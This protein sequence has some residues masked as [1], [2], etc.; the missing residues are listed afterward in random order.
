MTLLFMIVYKLLTEKFVVETA[1]IY[2]Y[3]GKAIWMK[4]PEGYPEFLD[5][6][7]GIVINPNLYCVKVLKAIYGLR[8][9]AWPWWKRFKASMAKLSYYSRLADPCLFARNVMSTRK[10]S[11]VIICV[12]DGGIFRSQK[13]IDDIITGLSKDFDMKPLGKMKDL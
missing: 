9:A 6:V 11:I 1:F 3:L 2:S 7:H 5:E 13:D 12:D 8:Q 10:P 4:L